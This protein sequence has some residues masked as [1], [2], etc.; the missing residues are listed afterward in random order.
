MNHHWSWFSFTVEKK[1]HKMAVAGG[2]RRRSSRVYRWILATSIVLVYT[3]FWIQTHMAPKNDDDPTNHHRYHHNPR[4]SVESHL[5]GFKQEHDLHPP[6]KETS[7][8]DPPQQKDPVP[9]TVNSTRKL[10]QEKLDQIYLETGKPYQGDLWE[11]SD[12]IPQWMKEYFVWHRQERNK[13]TQSNSTNWESQVRLLVMQCLRGC[14]EKCGG[15]ADRLKPF[16][17]VLREASMTQRLFLIHWT[18]PAP[19]EEYLVPP[20]HGMDWRVPEWLSKSLHDRVAN[21][22]RMFFRITTLKEARYDHRTPLFR[23]RIQS[24]TGGAESYNQELKPGEPTF[25]EVYHDVW[26]TLFTPSPPVR[27]AIESYME[28]WDFYPGAFTAAHLRALYGRIKERTNEEATEWAR[29]AINC[30]STLRPGGPFLF[31]SD[32]SFSTQAAIS[33]GVQQ[34]TLVMAR[35]HD[36]VPLHIDQ[37]ENL[38]N[39]QP[40][41][42]Y[43][44]FVDLLLM[45]MSRCLTYN[46]GGFGQ[47]ALLIGYNST[48]FHHQKTSQLGIGAP[49]NWT[50]PTQ[51]QQRRRGNAQRHKKRKTPRSKMPPLFLPPMVDSLVNDNDMSA[52]HHHRNLREQ[53]AFSN[54]SLPRWMTK[55]FT[56]HYQT[57]ST[58]N[59]TNWD[60]IKYLIMFCPSYSHCGGISDRLKTLP[61]IVLQAARHQRLLLIDWEKPKPLQEFL[62]PP[63]GGVDW[64]VPDWLVPQVKSLGGNI[65]YGCE[66]LSR[67]LY[68][69]AEDIVVRAKVQSADAGEVGYAEQVHSSSTYPDVFHGLFRAFFQPVPRLQQYMDQKMKEYGLVPGQ[70][71]AVHLRNMYGNRKWRHPNDTIALTMNGINCAS[72]LYPGAKIYFVADDELAV[73]A[74]YEYGQQRHLPIGTSQ[75]SEDPIHLDKDDYWQT[76]KSSDYDDT[77][78]DLLMLGQ[79][80]CVAYSNGGY[81]SFGSLISYNSNCSIRYFQGRKVARNC[82]WTTADG[83]AIPLKP[84]ILNLSAELYMAPN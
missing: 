62:I 32:H 58:L 69:K 9:L 43:D 66:D 55:Y 1:K 48:C 4:G 21:P 49:C 40:S 56:W 65:I 38:L 64:R 72:T 3:F 25:E 28:K 60:Q 47:W 67:K 12:Y 79:A 20:L 45:G 17:L 15:T 37:A 82:T 51:Q 19:L 2:R 29:N 27:A 71:A 6:A 63:P 31:A 52:E 50:D 54:Q 76:R 39:R 22:G 14:D 8:G 7:M 74:A 80:R 53:T 57:K 61:W 13:L 16:L 26:R 41:E 70:Y 84:P 24:V 68:I 46:R 34:S 42:F 73:Q 44:V 23:S 77:F 75:I 33:Y 81:G 10:L 36:N 59:S 30:A 78:L 18:I 5:Q 11:I 35:K 83:E